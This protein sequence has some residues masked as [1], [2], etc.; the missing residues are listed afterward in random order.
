MKLTQKVCQVLRLSIMFR[1]NRDGVEEDQHDNEPVKPLSL[2]SVPDPES[3]TL[4]GT[5]KSLAFFRR[6]HFGF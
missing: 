2:D 6:L 5:P 1:S 3:Q 4:F